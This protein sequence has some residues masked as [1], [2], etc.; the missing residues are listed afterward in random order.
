MSFNPQNHPIICV[1]LMF[2]YYPWEFWLSRSLRQLMVELVLTP[3]MSLFCGN[4][5]LCFSLYCYSLLAN[6]IVRSQGML[7][8]L[9]HS[10]V[11]SLPHHQYC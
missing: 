1:L 11:P 2:P 8:S 10:P 5:K 6:A 3:Q 4:Y 7:P 9:A